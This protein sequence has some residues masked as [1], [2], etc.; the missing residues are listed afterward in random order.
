MMMSDLNVLI[1]EYCSILE[2]ERQL[3]DRKE[4]LRE[5]I[6]AEMKRQDLQYTRSQFGT[7]QRVS[8]FKLHPRN[9]PLLGLLSSEDILPFAH[10]TPARVKE[11]LVPK[12]GRETL[13]PLFDIEKIDYL[14]VKRR[15][16]R[17]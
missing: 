17:Y 1:R 8:R 5:S 3:E 2:Q 13:L 15:A 4:R 14:M 6:T 7:A 12:Y 9:G 10:F 11:L 16:D